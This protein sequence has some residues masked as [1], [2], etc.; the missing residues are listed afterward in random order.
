MPEGYFISE[1]YFICPKGKLHVF[2]G[3]KMT[4]LNTICAIATPRGMGGV[5]MIRVSGADCFSIVGKIVS[6][7]I[8]SLEPRK[9]YNCDIGTLDKTMIAKF[10]APNSFTG[11]DCIELY[12]HG[13]IALQNAVLNELFRA[14]AA[15]AEPG[16]FTHRA[17]INGKLDLVEAEAI[18]NIIHAQTENALSAASSGVAGLL[19]DKIKAIRSGLITIVASLFVD[20]DFEEDSG[21]RIQD[22]GFSISGLQEL[23]ATADNGIIA[24]QG[25]NVAIV[26]APNVGKSSLLNALLGEDRAIVTD[27]AGTT[28][29]II[30]A[31]AN[32]NGH[33]VNFI[34][35]AGIRDTDDKIE[36]I[37]IE[38]ARDAMAKADLVLFVVDDSSHSSVGGD[39]HIAPRD[40]RDGV[41]YE[42]LHQPT[43]VGGAVP[44]APAAQA[45]C[46]VVRNKC[47]TQNKNIPCDIEISAKTGFGIEKL[48]KKITAACQEIPPN[49][50]IIANHRQKNQIAHAASHLQS[51]NEST[52]LDS[53]VTAIEAAI[54]ALSETIGEN[55]SDEIIS[56]IFSKFCVGK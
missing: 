39:A 28:R 43:S 40:A 32:I 13:G 38:R 42:L 37:G 8:A 26:G 44:G 33:L 7:N 19:S 23:I 1:G 41:P 29:D 14:G 36:Q 27:I 20:M 6:V 4:N 9:M 56:E 47:D 25:L 53:M 3:L 17:F 46:I 5:A 49:I 22:L 21:F 12:I 30:H 18:G 48:C 15:L 11:E 35:T 24:S 55:V 52:P 31:Q 2:E 45:P 34:D 54:S 16:E 10:A 50:P 51:I